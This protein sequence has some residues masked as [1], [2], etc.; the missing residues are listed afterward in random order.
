M[1]Q[2]YPR[3]P[4]TAYALLVFAAG[5]AAL[6]LSLTSSARIPLDARYLLLCFCAMAVGTRFYLKPP[7]ANLV[8]P[9]YYFFGLLAALA[10]DA[11]AAIP[12]V[13]ASALA[14]SLRLGRRRGLAGHDSAP[15]ARRWR[16]C[17]AVPFVSASPLSSSLRLGRRGGLVV[18]DS[19]L[20]AAAML[21][22]GWAAGQLRAGPGS[23]EGW[24]ARAPRE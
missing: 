2:T 6:T 11:Y 12:L 18:H 15:A 22:A 23:G 5:V 4:A 21:A 10:Y 1:I 8:V 19:A 9:L 13:S 17:A 16:A 14:S 20:A 7:R 24:G 3:R